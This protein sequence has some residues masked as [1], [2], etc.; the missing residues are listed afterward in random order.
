MMLCS[1][2]EPIRH[3][4]I[5]ILLIL[6]LIAILTGTY[7]WLIS[8]TENN[9]ATPYHLIL[10]LKEVNDNLF[11]VIKYTLL[12]LA[13]PL[14]RHESLHHYT[15]LTLYRPIP[16]S[17]YYLARILGR[18]VYYPFVYGIIWLFVIVV[19]LTRGYTLP[20]ASFSLLWKIG[21][22]YFEVLC[23]ISL[24][25]LF[26]TVASFWW[27]HVIYFA[28]YWFMV[29]QLDYALNYNTLPYGEIFFKGFYILVRCL[30]NG[31]PEEWYQT[32]DY[33][34][35]HLLRLI[36]GISFGLS[37]TLYLGIKSFKNT[38]L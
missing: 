13:I 33:S 6:T 18:S 29:S 16:R 37:V 2:L 3:R 19:L 1:F 35:L 4:L 25:A 15:D 27:F 26:S 8:F 21:L 34:P 14:I 22:Q 30:L 28:G 23:M 5:A 31:A 10:F 38:D 36:M 9:P 12:I 20:S 17:H 32:F 24:L 11:M 7:F